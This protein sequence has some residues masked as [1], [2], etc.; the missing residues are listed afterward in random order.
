MS[1]LWKGNGRGFDKPAGRSLFQRAACQDF[2]LS[3]LS[4]KLF[5][6]KKKKKQLPSSEIY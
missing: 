6:K 1:S 5:K 2:Y 4:K 3:Y